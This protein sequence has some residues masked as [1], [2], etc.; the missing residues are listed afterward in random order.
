VKPHA[1]RGLTL[2]ELLVVLAII[3]LVSAAVS[4][5]IRPSAER[6][7]ERQA[8]R[9]AALFEAARAQSQSSGSPLRWQPKAEGFEFTGQAFAGEPSL[10]KNWLEGSTPQ[11]QGDLP[12]VLGPEPLI[13]AQSIRLSLAEQE[14]SNAMTLELYTDG[15]A[16]FQ[17]RKVQP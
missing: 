15:L 13:P 14:A 8:Q 2:L 16:A 10:P 7:L 6:Q 11:V 9:L 3:G 17:I 4:F 5:A 1:A 12:V